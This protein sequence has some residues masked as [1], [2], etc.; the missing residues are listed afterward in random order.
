MAIE[1]YNV[2]L[3]KKDKMKDVV[4]DKNGNRYF[5][6]GI[7]TDG[8]KVSVAMGAETANNA[9]KNKEASKGKGWD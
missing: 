6:K 4:I 8:T 3:K 2:K 1:G 5:A 9:I 7:G